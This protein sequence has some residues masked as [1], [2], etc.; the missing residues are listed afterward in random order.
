MHLRFGMIWAVVAAILVGLGTSAEQSRSARSLGSEVPAKRKLRSDNLINDNKEERTPDLF[1][2]KDFFG[3]KFPET[4]DRR[5]RIN[6]DPA[7]PAVA[8]FHPPP[9]QQSDA[10]VS[11]FPHQQFDA[12]CP[13][14]RIN[15]STPQC[16]RSRINSLTR[17]C[18]GSMDSAYLTMTLKISSI[19]CMNTRVLQMQEID[20][21]NG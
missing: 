7:V 18:L 8:K 16:P 17:Q 19:S 12:Q 15:N 10:A 14:S 20:M 11:T 13:R 3:D 21:H 1:S 4:I 6:T 9:H 2:F 5:S